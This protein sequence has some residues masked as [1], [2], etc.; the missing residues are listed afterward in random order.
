MSR[1]ALLAPIRYPLTAASEQTVTR[2]LDL[3]AQFDDAHLFILH[4]NVRHRGES[5]TRTEFRRD[6]EAAVDPPANASCHVRDAYLIENAI[7]TEATEQ[8]IDYV[9]IGDSMRAR[10]HRLLLDRL[11][12]GVDLEA[13]LDQRLDAEVVVT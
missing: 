6:I 4:V 11:G 2:A 13:V 8:D 10:W 9:V 1:T 5:V 3:A 7:L 12:V